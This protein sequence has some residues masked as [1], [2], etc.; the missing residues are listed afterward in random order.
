MVGIEL[1]TA[2]SADKILIHNDSQLVVVQVNAEYESKDP[3][4]AKY[5]VLVKQR[6]AGFSTWKLE[7]VS[8]DSNEKE[9][10]LTVVAASLPIIETIFLPIYY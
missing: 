5:V 8:K 6:L 4:M 10:A 9:N 7:H 2:L 1:V 3:R